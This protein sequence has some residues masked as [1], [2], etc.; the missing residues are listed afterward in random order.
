MYPLPHSS[1]C[2]GWFIP[3]LQPFRCGVITFHRYYLSYSVSNVSKSR[4]ICL[5]SDV[6]S[7]EK[8]IVR[9]KRQL[10]DHH[11]I[12]GLQVGVVQ[13]SILNTH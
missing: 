9:N 8:I 4:I 11:F 12:I 5:C 6:V 1:D 10:M 2:D 3:C 13:E 7:K